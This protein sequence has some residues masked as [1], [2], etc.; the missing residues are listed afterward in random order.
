VGRIFVVAKILHSV[1]IIQHPTFEDLPIYRLKN[2]QH[3]YVDM[4]KNPLVIKQQLDDI[5]VVNLNEG[6]LENT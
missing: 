4:A 3:Y 5:N 1:E 6:S 2:D